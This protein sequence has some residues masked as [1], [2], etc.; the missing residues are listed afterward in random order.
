MRE[1][2][3]YFDNNFKDENVKME[4]NIIIIDKYDE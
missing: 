4:K 3:K 2:Q 1:E